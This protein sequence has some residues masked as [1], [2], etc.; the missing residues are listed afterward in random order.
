MAEGF[1]QNI[2]FTHNWGFG[3]MLEN[4]KTQLYTE[5]RRLE[6][7]F[8]ANSWK[9]FTP[10][11]LYTGQEGEELND[12]DTTYFDIC[13]ANILLHCLDKSWELNANIS[14]MIT[15]IGY[16]AMRNSEILANDDERREFCNSI[17]LNKYPRQELIHGYLLWFENHRNDR[18][19]V[20]FYWTLVM[21][22][23]L[24]LPPYP[25][26]AYRSRIMV[27]IS[28][29]YGLTEQALNHG[30]SDRLFDAL[31]IGPK[32]H[33]LLHC[34]ASDGTYRDTGRFTEYATDT[35]H[36]FSLLTLSALMS[37]DCKWTELKILG[38]K[39]WNVIRVKH[40]LVVDKH[41]LRHKNKKGVL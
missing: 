24:D 37:R 1:G 20:W 33:R 4:I 27:G 32:L 17:A 11:P 30:K 25:H 36:E 2:H 6:Q 34:A 31:T 13:V 7:E 26:H 14:E 38:V 9:Y 15:R 28:A 8:L 5:T 23:F 40:Q 3:I 10:K 29:E 22:A 35:L 18:L 21:W 41:Y 12:Y 39:E 16:E 19:D